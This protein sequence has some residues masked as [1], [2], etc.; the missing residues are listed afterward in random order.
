M[1]PKI[2]IILKLSISCLKKYVSAKLTELRIELL[3]KQKR[4]IYKN[5]D[6]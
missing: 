6:Y 4:K 5:I 1:P 3:T 2:T